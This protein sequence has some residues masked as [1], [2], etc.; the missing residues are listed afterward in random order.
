MSISTILSLYRLLEKDMKI[1]PQQKYTLTPLELLHTD[2][3]VNFLDIMNILGSK[4]DTDETELTD[5]SIPLSEYLSESAFE[6]DYPQEYRMYFNMLDYLE[7]QI[8]KEF[9][10]KIEKEDFIINSGSIV[11]IVDSQEKI[12]EWRKNNMEKYLVG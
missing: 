1:L 2:V 8:E 12:E 9:Q 5:L 7:S 10:A 4:S 6:E 11:D 3:L